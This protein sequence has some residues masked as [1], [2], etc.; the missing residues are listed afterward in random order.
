MKRQ[1]PYIIYGKVGLHISQK[2]KQSLVQIVGQ[3]IIQKVVAS[4][5]V[6]NIIAKNLHNKRL[7]RTNFSCH[8][9]C[10]NTQKSRHQKFAR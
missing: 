2:V 6:V 1:C 10:K 3:C 8:L 4:A 7:H 5:G 9:F